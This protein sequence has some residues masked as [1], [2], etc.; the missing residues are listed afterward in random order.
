MVPFSHVF[1]F[2]FAVMFT[3]PGAV[4]KNA[5]P[6]SP[7]SKMHLSDMSK[8]KYASADDKRMIATTGAVV[9]T[10]LSGYRYVD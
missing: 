3:D 6:L 1:C 9:C 8:T 10:C 4:P 5:V 7:S 2:A